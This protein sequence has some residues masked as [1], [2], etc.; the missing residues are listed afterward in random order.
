MKTLLKIA[1]AGA[2]L[3]L[4]ATT[5]QATTQQSRGEKQLQAML[6]GRVAGKPQS[7]ISTFDSSDNLQVIDNVGLVYHQGNTIWVAR[8]QNPNMLDSNDIPVI[9]RWTSQ[10]C[11]TDIIRTI[12]RSSGISGGAVFLTQWVPYTKAKN[13]KD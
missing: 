11:N 13:G 7:C 12:D 10:L 5:A 8:A 6:K 4:G 2:V 3:A 1:A 9:E